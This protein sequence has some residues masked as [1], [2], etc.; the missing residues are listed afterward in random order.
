MRHQKS[1][2]DLEKDQE[3]IEEE[4]SY[5]TE[6]EDSQYL[7]THAAKHSLRKDRSGR[8]VPDEDD[9]S[10]DF[11]AA[12]MDFFK[13]RARQILVEQANPDDY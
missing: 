1:R 6:A 13:R 9:G 7:A 2:T 4:K 8:D 12:K 10:F 5:A 11:G 3:A